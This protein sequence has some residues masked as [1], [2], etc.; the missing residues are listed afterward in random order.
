MKRQNWKSYFVLYQ[1]LIPQLRISSQAFKQLNYK[2]SIKNTFVKI[3]D[4]HGLAP[5][6]TRSILSVLRLIPLCSFWA[7]RPQCMSLDFTMARVA[8]KE[9][10]KW[11]IVISRVSPIIM[12]FAI[13]FFFNLLLKPSMREW[14]LEVIEGMER[15]K[16][17]TKK[18]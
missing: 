11:K 17:V 12:L 3:F 5:S 6:A 10:Q 4:L 7:I 2:H 16:R 8:V 15:L 9:K 1:G 18:V 14:H 13:F